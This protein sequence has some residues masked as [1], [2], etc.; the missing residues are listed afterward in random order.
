MIGAWFI[1]ISV[2]IITIFGA[3]FFSIEVIVHLIRREWE[4]IPINLLGSFAFVG[5]ILMLLDI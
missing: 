5:I 1:A 3:L 2:S 4:Y